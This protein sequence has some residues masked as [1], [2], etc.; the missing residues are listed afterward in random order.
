[1]DVLDMSPIASNSYESIIDKGTF[2]SI[3]CSEDS[4]SKIEKMLDEVYRI[5]TSNGVYIL[6]SIGDESRRLHFFVISSNKI[7]EEQMDS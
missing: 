1:M 4:D 2:D 7:A 3:I 6:I 5:L